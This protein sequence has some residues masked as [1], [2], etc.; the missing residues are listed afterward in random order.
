MRYK[1]LK[2]KEYDNRLFELQEIE[3]GIMYNVDFYTNGE[4]RPPK[5]AD[6]T[7]ESWDKWLKS[8]VGKTLEL[9]YIVPFTYFSGGKNRI[10]RNPTQPLNR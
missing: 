1:V 4:F 7:V 3:T 10:V 6:K 5:Y 8:F 9:E 2:Q